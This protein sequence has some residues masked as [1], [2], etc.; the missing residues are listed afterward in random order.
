[1][2]APAIVASEGALPRHPSLVARDIVR[3]RA[4]A[5]LGLH[6]LGADDIAETHLGTGYYALAARDGESVEDRCPPPCDTPLAAL[7]ALIVRLAEI[8]W[9]GGVR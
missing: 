2:N 9:T 3:A 5:R 4:V 1:M 8:Q 7:H 6:V